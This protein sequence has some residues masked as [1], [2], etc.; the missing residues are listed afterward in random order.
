MKTQKITQFE[1]EEDCIIEQINSG[2]VT[3]KEGIYQLNKLYSKYQNVVK[4]S[5]NKQKAY[6]DELD[7]W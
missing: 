3:Q 6:D 7:T 4:E 2:E 5:A 1:R